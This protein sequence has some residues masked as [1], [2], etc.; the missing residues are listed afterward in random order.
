MERSIRISRWVK[1]IEDKAKEEPKK[2]IRVEEENITKIHRGKIYKLT[3]KKIHKTWIIVLVV[4]QLKKKP[5]VQL[6]WEYFEYRWSIPQDFK[7]YPTV[8][9]IQKSWYNCK[10][11]G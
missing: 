6:D 5:R 10:I 1:P 9:K 7:K 2:E 4:V 3:N 8:P 11:S